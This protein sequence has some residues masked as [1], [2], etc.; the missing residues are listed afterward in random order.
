LPIYLTW[1]DRARLI[2]QVLRLAIARSD[3]ELARLLFDPVAD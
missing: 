1:P 2:P 3:D